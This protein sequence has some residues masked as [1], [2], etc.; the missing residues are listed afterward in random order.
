VST[1]VTG[2][3][4][5]D[6]LALSS[7]LQALSGLVVEVEQIVTTGQ[8]AVMPLLWVRGATREDVERTFE[9]DP[10]VSE[11]VLVSDFDDELLYRMEWTGQ[12]DL[13]LEM[14]T[15]S[16]AT[17]LNAVSYGDEWKLRVLYPDR[18]HFSSTHEFCDTHG[19]DF[20]IHSI[21][22]LEGEPA[23]RF[24]LT[25]EQYEVLATATEKGYFKVPREVT[26]EALAEEFGVSHQ[27]VSERLRR[28]I[29]GLVEDA[30]F[31]GM[32]DPD[33]REGTTADSPA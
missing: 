6:D 28:A 2:T 10:T 32:N 25:D 23:G 24:G 21:R 4:P 17:I 30:L 1:I 33:S 9:E 7:S 15:N 8:E 5:A 11:V 31:V 20:E 19:I 3:V 27:A 22:E 13:I 18:I 29:D 16:E 12:V 26:L 14:L